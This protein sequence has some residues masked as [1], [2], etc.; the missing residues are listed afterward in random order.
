MPRQFFVGLVLSCVLLV[1][2][3]QAGD[4]AQWRGPRRNGLATESPPLMEAIPKGGLKKAWTSEDVPGDKAGG[5]GSVS[6]S[7]GRAY[8]F[9]C[10]RY[11]APL[12]PRR[13]APN[14]FRS[15]GWAPKMPKE[16]SEAVEKARV[17]PERVML[18]DSREVNKWVNDW[19]K[20]NRKKE[21]RQFRGVN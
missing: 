17:S 6:V 20:T 10:Y 4:W 15:L 16:F 13:L 2:T 3:A 12:K 21:Y 19:L 1:P 14:A 18:R 8:V 7:G 5:W 11:D 9:A